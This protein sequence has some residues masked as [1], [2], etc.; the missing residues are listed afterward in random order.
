MRTPPLGLGL[1]Y[2]IAPPTVG[3]RSHMKPASTGSAAP[4]VPRN[5]VGVYPEFAPFDA[6]DA[7]KLLP[8]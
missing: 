4:V 5:D 8:R 3:S 6:N 1:S 2:Q 7:S